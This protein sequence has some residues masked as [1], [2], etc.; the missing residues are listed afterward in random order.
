MCVSD[1]KGSRLDR[2]AHGRHCFAH[3]HRARTRHVQWCSRSLLRSYG[4]SVYIRASCLTTPAATGSQP[5]HDGVSSAGLD[6][7]RHGQAR[8]ASARRVRAGAGSKRGRLNRVHTL[9]PRAVLLLG[10]TSA[11]RSEKGHRE[12]GMG[13]GVWYG[14]EQRRPWHLPAHVRHPSVGG[15]RLPPPQDTSAHHRRGMRQ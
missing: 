7:Y 4:S 11:C 9:S 2:D 13:V 3:L 14:C 15:E 12:S 5:Q 10:C 6:G 1:A 8:A